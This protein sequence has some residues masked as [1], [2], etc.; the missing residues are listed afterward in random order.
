MKAGKILVIDDDRNLLEVIRMR[1]ES[2]NYEVT[3]TLNEEEALNLIK[4]ESFDL[5]IIDLQLAQTDG[6]TLMEEIHLIVPDLPIIILTAYGSIESAVEAVKRGAY[7]YLTKPFDPQELL[8]HVEK[9]QEKN[10]LTAD[11]KILKELLEERYDHADIIAKSEKMQSVLDQVSRIAKTD[12]T[13][14]IY[15]ES[16]TG[17]ELVARAIHL[18]SA[19]PDKP[20]V[21]VNCAAI[22]ETLLE[23]EF[24]G[25]EKGAFT[26]AM[27]SAKGFFTQAHEGTIFLDEIANMSLSL[28]NKILR[29]LQERQ[30]YSVGGK[31]P[32]EVD[33]RVI[34]ATNKDLKK[35]VKEGRFRE[36]L[37]YRMHVIPINLPS[38]REK[39]EDIP[40][41]VQFFIQKFSKQMRKDV[42]GLTPQAMQKLMLH[43]WPGNVRELENT[44]EYA[45]AMTQKN[46]IADD[47]VLQG[48]DVSSEPLKPLKEAKAAFEKSYVIHLLELT[49]GNISKASELAGK[50]RA[51]FYN[52][53]KKYNL[54]PET[55]KKV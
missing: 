15:G 35:E 1:L 26:G 18:S 25:Y 48:N 22:P 6:I 5:S 51:D 3:T 55:F 12:S 42:K 52:L 9:A 11:I 2:E 47:L 31:K 29:V 16:G 41:L 54:D 34:V 36:D 30:F 46:V 39:K 27:Q 43:D 23:S 24:F 10:R 49:K 50:Y 44:I 38:L 13:V 8:R 20:F 45:M 28:Q 14:Y 17:K 7:N 21:A 53:L 37:F 40:S 32:I 19:R 4:G 33:V